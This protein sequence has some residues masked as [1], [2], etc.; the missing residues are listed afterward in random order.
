MSFWRVVNN[1]HLFYMVAL[2]VAISHAPEAQARPEVQRLGQVHFPLFCTEAAQ[3]FFDRGVA[4][5]HSF[6]YEKGAAT[7]SEAAKQ[8]PSCAM[9]YWGL[10]MTHFHPLWE[11]PNQASLDAGRATIE[12]AKAL[13]LQ[14]GRERDFIAALATFYQDFETVDHGSR[15]QAYEKAMEQLNQRYPDDREAEIFYA[16]SLLGTATASPPDKNYTK[17]KQAGEIL[18]PLFKEQPEHPGL[19]H[20]IIH[21][22]DYPELALQALEA[23]RRYAKIAPDSPH[24][25]HMPSHIFTRLG[26][27]QESI[28]SNLDSAAAAHRHS[29]PG[30]ELHAL[31]YLMYAYLQEGQD[32]KAQDLLEKLPQNP[33]GIS[34]YF[35]GLYASVAMP[36]RYVLER[37]QWKKA[38]LLQAPEGVFPGGRYAFTEA[39][40]HFVRGLG[41]TRTGDV[42][43][44]RE[45]IAQLKAAREAV[46]HAKA[47]YWAGVVEVQRQT[48][49]AWLSLAEG[50]KEEALEQMRAAADREDALG[51]HPVTP[52]AILP[53][54]ELL[55][56][57][58]LELE[59]PEPALAEFE[60]TLRASPNRFNALFGAARAAELAGNMKKGRKFYAQLVKLAKSGDGKRPAVVDAQAFLDKQ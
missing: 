3:K 16:L 6:W 48:V 19:A 8:D 15:V 21:S 37:H 55:G 38:A 17:Q 50:K 43:T 5:L 44:A 54:R 1:V 34:S 36:A 56:E 40:F 22:Y 57:M 46:K 24:A 41:A 58:L 27:W 53:A 59:Q 4:L 52:G 45:A 14:T 11:P 47:D 18:I 35:A 33:E 31:D 2:V 51:K 25:L 12:K 29:L 28:V 9:A 39:V 42:A 13:A 49:T 26:L 30:D 20:Y 7:F 60:A 32:R 23:A 10:A